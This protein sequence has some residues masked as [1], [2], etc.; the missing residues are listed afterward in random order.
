[1]SD[2]T[3]FTDGSD[4]SALQQALKMSLQAQPDQ[5]TPEA[6]AAPMQPMSDSD[7]QWLSG[8]LSEVAKSATDITKRLKANFERIESQLD[9][10]L[11]QERL[12]EIQTL[13]ED[14]HLHVDDLDLAGDCIKLGGHHVL[15]KCLNNQKL[16]RGACETLAVISQNNLPAQQALFELHALP[17]YLSLLADPHLEEEEKKK[18]LYALSC[19]CRGYPAAIQAFKMHQGFYKLAPF[20]GNLHSLLCTKAVFLVKSLIEFD[21]SLKEEVLDSGLLEILLGKLDEPRT[22]AHEYILSLLASALAGGSGRVR[23]F[24]SQADRGVAKSVQRYAALQGIHE[25][26]KEACHSILALL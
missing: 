21:T 18:V 20:I 5:Q 1:M 11:S 24:C 17:T 4:L 25:E 16:V 10:E 23:T 6:S 15:L 14:V 22:E 2:F 12:T 7:K 13:I 26:E 8:A 3:D 19:L 9:S